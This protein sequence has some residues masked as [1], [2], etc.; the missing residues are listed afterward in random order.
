MIQYLPDIDEAFI[1]LSA[2]TMAVGWYFIRRKQVA[3]HRALML[4]GSAF[5]VMFF[6]LYLARTVFIG[7]TTF[8]GPARWRPAYYAF[9][10]SHS[11]LATVAAVLGIIT[12][13]LAFRKN[14]RRHRKFGPWTLVIWFITAI[15]G[16]AVYLLLYVIYPS[17]STTSLLHA[18]LGH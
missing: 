13:T 15:T 14:F 5:A 9:L 2:I 1:L 7:D 16:T 12:L 10:Q 11:V 3:V 4:T 17:G 6:L 18:W 8:G